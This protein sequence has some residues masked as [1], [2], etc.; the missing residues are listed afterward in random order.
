[1][2]CIYSD[3]KILMKIIISLSVHL[4]NRI[5]R[6]GGYVYGH[7]LAR[8]ERNGRRFALMLPEAV[9]SPQKSR[10]EAKQK[11]ERGLIICYLEE[12]I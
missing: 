2:Y 12:I 6:P 11:K 5:H 10:V 4:E 9:T 1:M 3:K 7:R 8:K